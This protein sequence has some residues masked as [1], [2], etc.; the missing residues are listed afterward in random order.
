MLTSAPPFFSADVLKKCALVGMHVIVE[1]ERSERGVG[2]TPDLGDMWRNG[3]TKS[4][5]WKSE[6]EVWSEDESVSLG[7]SRENNVCNGGLHVIGLY[8][9]G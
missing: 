3:C 9:P 7:V 4:P 2:Q 1:D 8:G 6:D 5:M